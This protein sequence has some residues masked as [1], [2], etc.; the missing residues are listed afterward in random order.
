MSGFNTKQCEQFT[1]WASEGVSR[2]MMATY[3]GLSLKEFEARLKADP[4]A[5]RAV[6]LGSTI[7]EH[8]Y[9]RRVDEIAFGKNQNAAARMTH[10]VM[11]YEFGWVEDAG[12][13]LSINISL[14]PPLDDEQSRLLARRERDVTPAP[15]AIPAEFARSEP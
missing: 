9:L 13:G 8:N 4:P 15:K 7:R 1:K 5:E 6:A 3:S 2:K 12:T 11:R 10:S 14:P